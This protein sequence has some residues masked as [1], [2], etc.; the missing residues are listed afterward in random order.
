MSKT[1]IA[2]LVA[3]T[4]HLAGVERI[5]GVV[6][7]SLN[8]LTDSLRRQG[9]IAW[10]HVRNEEAAAFAAGAEA[11]VAFLADQ[12]GVSRRMVRIV[13]G[14]GSRNKLIEVDA[15]A[16]PALDRILSRT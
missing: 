10:V 7:D 8:G 1:T 9:K 16:L 14:I 6:G 5:Y 15:K 11:L 2:D 3:Q 4:L 12:L 13:S